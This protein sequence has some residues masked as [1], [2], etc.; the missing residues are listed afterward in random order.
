MENRGTAPNMKEPPTPLEL[1]IKKHEKEKNDVSQSLVSIDKTIEGII[2]KEEKV[3][4]TSNKELK[5]KY[6]AQSKQSARYLNDLFETLKLEMFEA[7]ASR[8]AM[9]R[10]K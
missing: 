7:V 8:I 9:E 10:E 1:A 6:K 5:K 3:S 2:L 4:Q